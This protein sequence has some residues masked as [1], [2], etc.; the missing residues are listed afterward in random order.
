MKKVLFTLLIAVITFSAQAQIR[1]QSRLDTLTNVDT[2][3]LTFVQLGSKVKSFEIDATKIS[4]TVAGKVYLQGSVSGNYWANIDS[5]VLADVATL[6]AKV[7][8]PTV[9]SYASYRTKC[10]TTGTQSFSVQLF[11]VRRPD[12]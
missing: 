3:Y 6:Q 11:T 4:G 5:L 7:V 9:T 1:I 8:L 12:E 2:S 10:I